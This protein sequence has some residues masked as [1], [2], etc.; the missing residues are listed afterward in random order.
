MMQ[1]EGDEIMPAHGLTVRLL[2]VQPASLQKGCMSSSNVVGAALNNEGG[3][4]SEESEKIAVD[5]SQPEISDGRPSSASLHVAA[6]IICGERQKAEAAGKLKL[7]IG[8]MQP[9]QDRPFDVRI[10][11]N[12][13]SAALDVDGQR[14]TR[15]TRSVPKSSGH[16]WLRNTDSVPNMKVGG[17][18]QW[19]SDMRGRRN[20]LS[21]EVGHRIE[22]QELKH[23]ESQLVQ[24]GGPWASSHWQ[25]AETPRGEAV[26][27]RWLQNRIASLQRNIQ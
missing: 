20:S 21:L 1:S 13:E 7:G 5:H 14:S 26:S 3:I 15:S 16:V 8:C 11:S 18:G 12:L 2:P 10:A 27:E 24:H 19:E 4:Y 6:A 22:G 17:E 23:E 9:Q 25:S